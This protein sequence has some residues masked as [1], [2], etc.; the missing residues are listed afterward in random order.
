MREKIVIRGDILEDFL[1]LFIVEYIFMIG[2]FF[3]RI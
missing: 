3:I 1:I 2:D